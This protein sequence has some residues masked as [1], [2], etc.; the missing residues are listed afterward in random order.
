MKTEIIPVIHM[1]DEDQVLDNIDLC[2]YVGINKVFLINHIVGVDE[3]LKC[4]YR[5]KQEYSDIW[6][7]INMLGVSTEIALSLPLSKIDALWCDASISAEKAKEVRKFEGL[8]FGGLAFKYQPQ[9]TDLESA[10]KEAIIATDIACTSGSGTGKAATVP[11]IRTIRE[12][13]GDHPMAI[14]SGVSVENILSYKGLANYL[15]VASSITDKNEMIIK[16]K[17][18]ELNNKLNEDRM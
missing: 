16:E 8:F 5:V 4:A 11:K 18:I 14:A 2:K 7:G 15:L 1:I 10:C 6:V 13:L 17:L 12:Y 9:P 3:L